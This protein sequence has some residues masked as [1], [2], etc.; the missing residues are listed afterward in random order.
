VIVA[1]A[2]LAT[3]YATTTL[4]IS[5]EDHIKALHLAEEGLNYALLDMHTLGAALPQKI[6]LPSGYDHQ[7]LVEYLESLD[8]AYYIENGGS[9]YYLTD[10]N[11]I[12]GYGREMRDRRI[13]RCE[14]GPYYFPLE[15]APAALYMDAN[16]V[17]STYDGSAFRIDG[18]DHTI[19]GGNNPGGTDKY[20]IVTTDPDASAG[21][22][23][24]LASNQK[25]RVIGLGSSPSV[26]TDSSVPVDI[27][28]FSAQLDSIADIVYP[29][30]VTLS[31]STYN[32]GSA[33][34]PVI[35]IVNGDA[36][37]G[38]N[39]TGYGILDIRGSLLSG[40]GSVV[41]TGIL[42]VHGE[43][44]WIA[45]TPDVIGS[46]WIKSDHVTLRISGNPSVL[47]SS[48]ALSLYGNPGYYLKLDTWEEL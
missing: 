40:H 19:S 48:E 23:D 8:P 31:S 3:V 44:T 6:T 39:L 7:Q 42:I 5:K 2:V 32:M 11:A 27:D 30:S 29:S 33:E 46:L 22:I 34:R 18:G 47:Y 41:W 16:S 26:A 38:G 28:E 25:N 36:T 1:V 43:E 20:G 14:Y 4:S 37:I 21:V 13:I 24:G 15:E 10:D 45:G 9:R 17:D 35:A 12:L